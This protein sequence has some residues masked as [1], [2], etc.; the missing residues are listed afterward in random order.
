MP[1]TGVLR[2]VTAIR[3]H[4]GIEIF[5]RRR[6]TDEDESIVIIRAMQDLARDRREERLGALG[7]AMVDQESDEMQ[8]DA[9]PQRI[10]AAAR[11]ARRAKFAFD[12]LDGLRAAAIVE[13]DAIS[14]DVMD[15][16]PIA[17]LEIALCGTSTLAKQRV[18]AVEAF[19]Q[20]LG[21]RKRRVFRRKRVRDIESDGGRH[22][23]QAYLAAR[24]FSICSFNTLIF[25]LYSSIAAL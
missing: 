15:C 11:K 1:K 13:I 25:S 9:V 2:V 21:D 22:R 8:L 6:G 19:E 7:L 17:G 16:E 20:D 14:N 18:M 24:A 12:A 23:G 4:V 3:R 5:G 10:G